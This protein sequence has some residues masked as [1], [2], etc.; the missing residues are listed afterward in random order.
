VQSEKALTG[1]RAGIAT[2]FYDEL[3]DKSKSLSLFNEI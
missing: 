1:L 2:G 3:R